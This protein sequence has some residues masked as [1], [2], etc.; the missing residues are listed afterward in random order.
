MYGWKMNNIRAILLNLVL[1]SI[2]FSHKLLYF[3]ISGIPSWYFEFSNLNTA[4][5]PTFDLHNRYLKIILPKNIHA[6]IALNNKYC[7]GE[8]FNYA[9][10]PF[11]ICFLF[12]FN[13]LNHESIVPL[14]FQESRNQSVTKWAF[15]IIW[16]WRLRVC[17]WA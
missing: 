2:L 13:S 5:T 12:Y 16:A 14:W 7:F 6:E 17:Y 1:F 3:S 9:S 4:P 10:M 11:E 8:Q 15:C